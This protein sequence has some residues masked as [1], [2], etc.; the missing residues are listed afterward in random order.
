MKILNFEPEDGCDSALDAARV[1]ISSR[2]KAE[3]QFES[4]NS[5]FSSI[6]TR[7][8]YLSKKFLRNTASL[9]QVKRNLKS[10]AS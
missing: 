2:K 7:M 5:L 4:K 8:I 6:G 10:R 9:D 3:T 1:R